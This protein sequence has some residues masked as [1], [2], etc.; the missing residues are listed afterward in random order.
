MRNG[1]GWMLAVMGG[2]CAA[3]PAWSQHIAWQRRVGVD[4]PAGVGLKTI[5][6]SARAPAATLSVAVVTHLTYYDR[7]QY[8]V[9]GTNPL[10]G[11]QRWTYDFGDA[12]E[13]ES[14]SLALTETLEGGDVV[15]VVHGQSAMTLWRDA[16]V[17]RLRGSDGGVVW[18]RNEKSASGHAAIHAIR[19]LNGTRLLLAGRSAT[20][21]RVQQWDAD[22]GETLWQRDL[23]EA[24][25]TLQAF[26]IADAP[27]DVGAVHLQ[28][29]TGAVAS[30]RL[31]G[32]NLTDGS[33]LW[34]RA[35]CASGATF[36]V[37]GK[38]LEQRL[39]TFAD[40]TLIQ[41]MQCFASGSA[42]TMVS[43]HS[44]ATGAEIWQRELVQTAAD[45]IVRDD[46][47]IVL[48]G[49]LFVDGAAAGL[50]RLSGADGSTLWTA[51]R[52]N[53][54]LRLAEADGRAFLLEIESDISG[55]ATTVN[56]AVH[57]VS[58]GVQLN[59]SEI[60]GFPGLMLADRIHLGAFVDGDVVVAGMSGAN[61]A[62]GLR[63]SSVRLHPASTT[64]W[65]SSL[66]VMGAHPFE[67]LRQWAAG[68]QMLASAQG[69]SGI[70]LAGV[71][72]KEGGDV[73]P[74]VVKIDSRNGQKLWAW[75]PDGHRNGS[76]H[77]V[78]AMADGDVVIAG[79]GGTGQDAF[80][81]ERLDGATGMATWTAPRTPDNPA[82][83]AASTGDGGIAVVVDGVPTRVSRHSGATGQRLWEAAIPEGRSSVLGD[84]RIVAHTD[85]DITLAARFV[86]ATAQEGI[87][88][89]HFRGS[90]GALTWRR[91]LP[92]EPQPGEDYLR[93]VLLPDG[94]VVVMAR[95]ELWRVDGGAGS[96]EWRVTMPF[97]VNAIAV[98]ATDV[99]LAGEVSTDRAVGRLRGHDGALLWTQV[100]PPVDP[101]HPA[102]TLSAVS[103]GS[104]GRLLAAGSDGWSA[105]SAVALDP[106]SGAVV[107]QVSD[108][109]TLTANAQ[110]AAAAGASYWPIA[111]VQ[112][113]DGNVLFGGNARPYPQTWTVSKVT[114][115]FADGLFA[116]GF[117]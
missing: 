111:I 64:R 3:M 7:L 26:A 116:D 25:R 66:P 106:V 100:L 110:G 37:D 18:T 80:L 113:T 17:V 46:T 10:D 39:R 104:D 21:G 107:W 34:T 14:A 5:T 70:V 23:S 105:Q 36:N 73:F 57:D 79:N 67:P 91:I 83:D 47:S 19:A 90:D 4:V 43:R 1:I 24:G 84:H 103:V 30:S 49:E 35:G 65:R 69:T 102:E 52:A 85:G 53:G 75:Q 115:N 112:T 108:A 15:V 55:Y 54:R 51:Q 82:L 44:I 41:V 16:C 87:H 20:V 76:A 11:S 29:S 12:C 2:V 86:S 13:Y 98:V 6:P 32:L 114:G 77:A 33:T 72:V 40:G 88:V 109:V 27:G 94:D 95:G 97:A 117:E 31:L 60:S 96:L 42:T 58:N 38:Q 8:R 45:A 56:L 74:R 99:V 81:L 92:A 68:T 71:G 101:L 93:L 62:A 22:T 28:V 78:V 50:A 59:R 61:R 63:Y 48:A 89:V 9:I